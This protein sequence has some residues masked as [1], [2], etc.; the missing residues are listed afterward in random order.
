MTKIGFKVTEQRVNAA[1]SELESRDAALL[2]R[3]VAER[4]ITARFATYLQR[5]FPE[6]DVDVEYNRHG[7]NPKTLPA[8]PSCGSRSG[9]VFPDV[10]VHRRGTDERNLLVVEVKKSTSRKP[11]DCDRAK[12]RAM[13]RK[14]GYTY[15]VLIELPTGRGAGERPKATWY[16]FRR[17]FRH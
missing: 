12:I 3:D 10:V 15:G 14:Y 9:Y 5:T 11:R 16:G 2:R 7:L 8:L 6:H 17:V 4:S 13:R 1:L